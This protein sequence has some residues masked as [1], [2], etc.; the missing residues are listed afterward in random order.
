MIDVSI[1][2]KGSDGL[3]RYKYY[4]I[5]EADE[6]E[7]QGTLSPL[8]KVEVGGISLRSLAEISTRHIDFFSRSWYGKE[9]L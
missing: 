3:H 6:L 8:R 5:S 9:R 7:K 4:L 1:Q 2:R